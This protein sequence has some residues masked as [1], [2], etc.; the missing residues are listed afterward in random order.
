MEFS[1]SECLYSKTK[2]CSKI[3]PK[4]PF[5]GSEKPVNKDKWEMLYSI[6]KDNIYTWRIKRSISSTSSGQSSSFFLYFN[7]YTMILRYFNLINNKVSYTSFFVSM[8]VHR[9]IDTIE[10]KKVWKQ[11][12]HHP[13]RYNFNMSTSQLN[14]IAL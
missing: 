1:Y 2:S 6:I 8:L 14:C 13:N 4:T 11:Y 12:L 10:K 5:M 7:D 9:S 3:S